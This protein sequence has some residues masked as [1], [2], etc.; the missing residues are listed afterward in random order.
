[1]KSLVLANETTKA[2]FQEL[3]TKSTEGSSSR[4]PIPI[5]DDRTSRTSQ[6]SS[7]SRPHSSATAAPTFLS[8]AEILH[9]SGSTFPQ[10]ASKE[11][12][13]LGDKPTLSTDSPSPPKRKTYANVWSTVDS[14]ELAL[15][16][17]ETAQWE[18][19]RLQTNLESNVTRETSKPVDWREREKTHLSKFRK[20]LV[21]F[22]LK[23]K[24]IDQAIASIM[25]PHPNAGMRTEVEQVVS[26]ND[27]LFATLH[28]F[29]A[30]WQNDKVSASWSYH[31]CSPL[32]LI[33]FRIT[34]ISGTS[35]DGYQITSK[36]SCGRRYMRHLKPP[37]IA[38]P[39]E[40]T[41]TQ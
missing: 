15:R 39:P 33:S 27:V 7:T 10:S 16:K 21:Q 4:N 2:A 29:G 30:P 31:R 19:D 3:F 1:M 8:I 25:T 38:S 17:V 34:P 28:H 13:V 24:K 22:G 6:L 36:T 12:P 9:E 35:S 20:S 5:S 37:R 41:L 11:L 23:K 14:L 40:A 18:R 26:Q 32:V